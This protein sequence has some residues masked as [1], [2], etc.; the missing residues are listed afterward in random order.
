MLSPVERKNGWQLPEH[1][2]QVN[3]YRLPH[4]LDRAVW[5]ANAVRD[6]LRHD[7]VEHLGSAEGV[8]VV[9]ES[10]CLKKGT[11]SVG[12]K[13]QYSGTAGRVENCPRGVYLTDAAAKGPTFLDQE[14]SLPQEGANDPRR[15]ERA[16]VPETTTF[17]T[18]PQLAKTML[19]RAPDQG[20]P[21]A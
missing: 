13:R 7:V 17:A 6:D 12:V 11:P 21:A 20:V 1:L 16:F 3:P 5:D 4:L 9:D 18:K 10:A 15:R 2:G 19:Q 8:L 14:L